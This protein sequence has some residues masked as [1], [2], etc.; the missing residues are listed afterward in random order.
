M[1]V[2]YVSGKL[3][4]LCEAHLYVFYVSWRL[5]EAHLYVFYVSGRLREAHLYVF[6]VSWRLC[7]AHSYVFY[8]SRRLRGG[9]DSD[10]LWDRVGPLKKDLTRVWGEE[11]GTPG[12]PT[13]NQPNS[14]GG[15]AKETLTRAGGGREGII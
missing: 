4:A 1:Y 15:S 14:P 7:E 8:V 13:S 3:R 2:F 12:G 5:W 6:Y 10:D 11:G 9:T